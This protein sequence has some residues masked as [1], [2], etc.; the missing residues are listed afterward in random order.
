MKKLIVFI[1]MRFRYENLRNEAHVKFHS[2]FVTLVTKY[3]AETLGISQ[4][5]AVYKP[6]FDDE[7]AALDQILKSELTVEIVEQDHLRDELY[8]GFAG[9]VKSF[10]H[11]FDPLKREAAR[12]L[13]I[14]V[15]HYGNV[16]DKSLDEESA[17]I[18]DMH[19]E[20]MKPE[21]AALVTALGGLDEWLV[22]LV[23]A[24]HKMESLM[25]E[26]Y[27]EVSKRP[28]IHMRSI[29]TEVDKV[30]RGIL[31]L[32]EALVRVNGADTNK[33]F[34]DELNA[35]MERYRDILAQE[36]GRRHPPKDLGA[37]DHC[38]VEPI[39]TQKYTEK[40]IIPIP[41]AYWR[42]EGKATVELVFAKD[43]SVTYKNN[44]EVGTA[45]LTLHGTGDYKGQKTVTF[46]IAR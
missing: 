32:L 9:N 25:M 39:D 23:Q 46:N 1:I 27:E 33:A 15:E 20:L 3:G 28:N 12:K 24:S 10:L 21:N 37:A 16:A 5:Y 26:R 38:V 4:P 8:R 41:T 30:F 35:V 2:N 22:T 31:D 29:R 13:E 6:L 17:A 36:A 42:E 14:I 40:A 7:V 45:D 43:F 18:N 44:V 11:H 34:I 19:R